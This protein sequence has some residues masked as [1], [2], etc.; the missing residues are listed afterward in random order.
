MFSL[1][2][3]MPLVDSDNKLY[4]YLDKHIEQIKSN[5]FLP[6]YSLMKDTNID[7]VL[8]EIALVNQQLPQNS[9]VKDYCNE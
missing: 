8:E 7:T 9:L 4:S 6:E 1:F 5:L 2:F 3:L